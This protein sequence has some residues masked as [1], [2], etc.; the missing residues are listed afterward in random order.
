MTARAIFYG[1][2][3]DPQFT[4]AA[5]IFRGILR[6]LRRLEREG[7]ICR[8]VGAPCCEKIERVEAEIAACEAAGRRAESKPAP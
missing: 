2:K 1:V 8:N 3:D 5:G 6:Q 7:K 4:R